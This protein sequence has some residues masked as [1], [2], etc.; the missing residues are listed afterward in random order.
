MANIGKILMILGSI[1]TF[2]F[3]A[4]STGGNYWLTTS[5]KSDIGQGLW[6]ICQ[7]SCVSIDSSSL[8]DWFKATRAF[9]VMA[10]L[11]AAGAILM[12]ILGMV[13][14]KIKSLFVS[15]FLFAAAGN[16]VLALAIFTSKTGSSRLLSYGWSYILG[17]IGAVG[18]GVGGLLGLFADK[19]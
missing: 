8:A 4:A 14:E 5:F 13:S 11:A 19:F 12:A 3:I 16:M 17:W 6:K 10:C 1:G 2:V 15:L 9:A 7:Y 18:G